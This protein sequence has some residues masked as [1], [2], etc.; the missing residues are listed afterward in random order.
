[1]NLRDRLSEE[2]DRPIDLDERY[3]VLAKRHHA[4]MLARGYTK[5]TNQDYEDFKS[6]LR[7]MNP[8][9]KQYELAIKYYTDLVGY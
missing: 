3:A 7:D 2:F 9:S 8:D 6:D 1:M 5:A 4:M